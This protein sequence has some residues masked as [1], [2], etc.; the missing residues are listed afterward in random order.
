LSFERG[1]CA[2]A[3][4]TVTPRRQLD[5]PSVDRLEVGP[6]RGTNRPGRRATGRQALLVVGDL[7]ASERD[8]GFVPGAD[9]RP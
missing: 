5:G 1:E 8:L 6:K 4:R 7:E 3:E 9:D 2:D